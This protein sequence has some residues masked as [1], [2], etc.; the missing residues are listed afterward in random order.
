MRHAEHDSVLF[1]FSVKRENT[2]IDKLRSV[3]YEVVTCLALEKLRQYC[4]SMS[5]KRKI[6]ILSIYINFMYFNADN[7]FEYSVR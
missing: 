3:K 1:P 6:I 4:L 7:F 5:L 2:L